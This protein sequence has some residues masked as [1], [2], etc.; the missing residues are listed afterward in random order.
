MNNMEDFNE[1]LYAGEIAKFHKYNK[2]LGD[3]SFMNALGHKDELQR[4]LDQLNDIDYTPKML[5]EQ[6]N[7]CFSSRDIWHRA[8]IYVSQFYVF[9]YFFAF[10]S[11][12]LRQ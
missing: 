4:I 6:V 10:F 11:P 3:I 12:I 8:C 7:F 5:S 1:L 9:I 2:L